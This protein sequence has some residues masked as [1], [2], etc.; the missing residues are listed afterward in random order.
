MVKFNSMSEYNPER[1]RQERIEAERTEYKAIA[2]R[3][4]TDLFVDVLDKGELEKRLALVD[5]VKFVTQSQMDVLAKENP[6][7]AGAD[8]LIQYEVGKTS[9]RRIPIVLHSSSRADTLHTL[10]H[11]A[12]HLMT[13]D[14]TFVHDPM[15]EP[16]EENFNDYLGGLHFE[17]NRRT[18]EV[19]LLASRVDEDTASHALFWE[20]TTDWIAE[21][22]LIDDLTD[23]EKEEIG[24]A[25]YF[26]RHWIGYLI[27][28]SPNPSELL[29]A[30]KESYVTGNE[31]PLRWCLHRQ[32][33]TQDDKFFDELLKIIGRDRMDEKRVDDWIQTVDESFKP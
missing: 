23:L 32:L 17:R 9:V 13:P 24:T 4:L 25:G 1:A 21:F 20:A 3:V 28:K 8:G 22:G 33:N 12:T 19:D 5:G 29:Q 30:V 15:A 11:E 18:K 31:D 2:M 10:M 7:E 27:R 26:E 14:S 16:G 6:T